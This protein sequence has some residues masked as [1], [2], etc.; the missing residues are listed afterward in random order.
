MVT[1]Q[2][3]AE[4][5]RKIYPFGTQMVV[6]TGGLGSIG[7]EA[8]EKFSRTVDPE[9]PLDRVIAEARRLFHEAFANSLRRHPNH[10]IPLSFLLAGRDRQSGRGF[11]CALSSRDNFS[12]FWI[13]TVNLPY[14]TGSNTALVQSRAS[15]VFHE[16]TA[17]NDIVQLDLYGIEA[18]RRIARFDPNV[19]F[20]IQLT[21]VRETLTDLFP[22]DD[23]PAVPNALFRIRV[24]SAS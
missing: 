17:S 2:P 8:R 11:L 5:I 22:I 19:G 6:C 18:M 16:M 7:H 23:V 3:W 10:T 21:L 9:D 20:P 4:A 15:R 24:P 1:G 14:F 13:R 12:P